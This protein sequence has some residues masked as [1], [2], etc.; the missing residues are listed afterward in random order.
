VL[1]GNR[2]PLQEL[3]PDTPALLLEMTEK[4]LELDPDN[5]HANAGELPEV[6]AP[7]LSDG[8]LRDRLAALVRAAHGD[9]SEPDRRDT[10]LALAHEL[11]MGTS[12]PQDPDTEKETPADAHAQTELGPSPLSKTA[13]PK[14]GGTQLGHSAPE[15]PVAAVATPDADAPD[16]EEHPAAVE[17]VATMDVPSEVTVSTPSPIDALPDAILAEE[18]TA[19]PRSRAGLWIG[20]GLTAL[21][22]GGIGLGL[23]EGD[24]EP[25]A[26]I[27][28][29]APPVVAADPG[30]TPMAPTKHTSTTAAVLPDGLVP[31]EVAMEEPVAVAMTETPTMGATMDEE[32]AP[33]R[34]ARYRVN[35]FPWGEVWLANRYMGRAPVTL[36]LPPGRHLVK[37][38][39]GSPSRNRTLNVRTGRERDTLEFDLA[40]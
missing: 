28:P 39:Q 8:M 34:L 14:T 29:E 33:A 7:F 23:T 24:V 38:G 26:Q 19:P 22:G 15:T 35:V 16:T 1:E 36:R 25:A 10:A 6:L 9:E 13:D 21:L 4:L 17:A 2:P 27:E 30:G 20:L 40:N 37:V 3:A 5:R 31:P 11:E 32:E 12:G 18:S